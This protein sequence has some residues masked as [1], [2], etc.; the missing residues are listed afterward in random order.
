MIKTRGA[1]DIW[2]F[3]ISGIQQDTR[4]LFARYP[5]WSDTK[6]LARYPAYSFFTSRKNH[7]FVISWIN[8]PPNI[9]YPARYPV[10]G[11]TECRISSRTDI[12]QIH[13]WCTPNKTS[14]STHRPKRQPLKIN[15]STV[16]SVIP[17][18]SIPKSPKGEM[19]S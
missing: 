14:V 4:F 1:P 3:S 5:A 19:E 12:Q 9:Q 7:F 8:V 10:S 11:K 13:I 2:P 6:Y 17:N 16:T 15:K 18:Q